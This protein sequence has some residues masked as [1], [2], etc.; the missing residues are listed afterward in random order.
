MSK[1]IV[2]A[3][4]HALPVERSEK[5]KSSGPVSRVLCPPKRVLAIYLRRRS[6]D[7]S[8]VLPS[9]SGGPPSLALTAAW[10]Q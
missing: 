2:A 8:I 6:H 10:P 7:V 5:K 1:S 3:Q 9:N 4:V